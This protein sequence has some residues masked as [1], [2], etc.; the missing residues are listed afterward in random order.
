VEITGFVHLP[1]DSIALASFN[2]Q[3]EILV[4]S[5]VDTSGY[6]SPEPP[7]VHIDYEL[8]GVPIVR[9]LV[10]VANGRF[11]LQFTVPQQRSNGLI[12]ALSPEPTRTGRAARSAQLPRRRGRAVEFG[13]KA[14]VRIYAWSG[15]MDAQG[16][17]N[18]IV[19][20]GADGISAG[21]GSVTDPTGGSETAEHES[22]PP[23]TIAALPKKTLLYQNSPNP[24][25]PTTTIQFDLAHAGHVE[26]HIY[27]V[28]G[29]LVRTLVKG[30]LAQQR[31]QFVWYGLDDAGAQV[32]SGLYFYRLD[33]PGYRNTRKMLLLQ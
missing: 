19:Y 11:E 14:R 32:P 20:V 29:R 1:G 15:S 8:P 18:S 26:L 10:P 21:A 13:S 22:A 12:P 17:S 5:S 24:F 9:Q 23:V 31:H 28:S 6:T 3:A 25:N 27:N 30:R 16:A 7:N 33:T 2:G 4:L